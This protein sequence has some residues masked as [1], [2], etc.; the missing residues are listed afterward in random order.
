MRGTRL[1]G[2]S[3]VSIRDLYPKGQEGEVIVVSMGQI[4]WGPVPPSAPDE[5]YGLP[6]TLTWNNGAL[7]QITLGTGLT[8]QLSY[9][10]DG[11]LDTILIT[12]PDM[13]TATK[14]LNYTNG[15]LTSIVL[16]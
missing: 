13:T 2:D 14:K 3:S 11:S 8:K 1:T 7:E 9:N 6:K 15:D 5:L 4:E 12:F 10:P 16:L